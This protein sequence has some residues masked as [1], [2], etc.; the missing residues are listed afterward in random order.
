[1]SDM[2]TTGSP[3]PVP[4]VQG[5]VP[6]VQGEAEGVEAALMHFLRTSPAARTAAGSLRNGAEVGI[7]F[8]NHGG[9][10]HFRSVDSKPQLEPGQPADPD[11]ELRLAPGAVRAICA[12]PDAH[13]G[14]LGVA[15][16]EHIVARDPEKRIRVK[17]RSG[18]VKLALRGWLGVL[19]KGGPTVIGWMAQKGLRGPSAVAVALSRLKD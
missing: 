13:V 19:A 11:F 5:E 15:F 10:W 8:S 12:K 17:L 4:G 2:H 7:T 1:M 9:E 18:L 16:F 14:D 6:G 3:V